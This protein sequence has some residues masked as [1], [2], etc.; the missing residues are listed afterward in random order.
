LPKKAAKQC[1]RGP[2]MS[3]YEFRLPMLGD[4]EVGTVA[5]W[6]VGDGED[7]LEGQDVVAVDIDKVTVDVAAPC[8]GR[9]RIDAEVGVELTVG[10]LLAW[11][12]DDGDGSGAR[13]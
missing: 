8:A 2:A 4:A 12:I 6:Y 1:R 3:E 11:I 7:V 9:L 13:S 10:S 5:E